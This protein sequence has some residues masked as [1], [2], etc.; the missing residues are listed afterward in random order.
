MIV[1]DSVTVR[2]MIK[3]TLEKMGHTDLS[4]ANDGEGALEAI[5]G[6]F[7]AKTPFQI[8]FLDWNLPNM[9]GLQVLSACTE[10]DYFKQTKVIM[11]TSVSEEAQI[12]Q[13]IGAGAFDYVVKP[14][15]MQ[16]IVSKIKKIEGLLQK[17]NKKE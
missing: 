5:K 14:F 16:T 3:T 4:Y 17:S 11:V 13:A 2:L 1:D 7:L 12:V 6:A 8:M 15:S 10:L 9:S